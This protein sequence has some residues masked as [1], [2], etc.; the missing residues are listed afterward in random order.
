MEGRVLFVND[1]FLRTHGYEEEELIGH[2]IEKL[3]CEILPD[4][5]RGEGVSRTKEGREFPVSV[6]RSAVYDEHGRKIGLVSIVQ[7]L[8]EQKRALADMAQVQ[9]QLNQ[10]RKMESVGRLA[11]GVAH[12]FNNLVTV[13]RGYAG[14]ALTRLDRGQPL[15]DPKIRDGLDQ[16]SRAAGRAAGLTRHL[17][18]FSRESA[19]LPKTIS[20]N[21]LVLGI[22]EMLRR[23]IGE[24][25]QLIVFPGTEEG[26]IHADA[27]LVEQI[28]VN[29]TVN[30]ADALPEGGELFIET[31]RVRVD[32]ALDVRIL[33]APSGY[34][35]S[36]Q[37]TDTGSGIPPELQARMFDPFFTT[38]EI[39]KGTG[40]GL[41]TVYGNRE[42]KR[43][44][45]L[46]PQH[47]RPGDYLP[48]VVSDDV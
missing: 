10:A 1:A 18:T 7:D 2:P 39:G 23:L 15:A 44:L 3:L 47:C 16:I 25:I 4:A 9:A 5:W 40:L 46:F 36:L 6:S 33:G 30:A 24:R 35:V 14:T 32:T 43:R 42:T 8:S 31:S 13:I 11:G 28:I 19:S 12:D 27:G 37:I 20:L 29:L 34:Y 21:E 26:F 38:K 17:L 48:R 22:E 45:H 41:S